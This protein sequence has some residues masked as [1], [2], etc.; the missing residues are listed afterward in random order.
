MSEEVSS[1]NSATSNTRFI[2]GEHQWDLPDKHPVKLDSEY[3]YVCGARAFVS[4]RDEL[5]ALV[6][7]GQP[8]KFVWTPDTP[9]P[10]YPEMVAF[11]LDALRANQRRSG[12]NTMFW[13][14]G[15]M[16]VAFL[17]A[18][19]A[20]DWH[21]VYRSFF[22][23]LGALFVAEGIWT[24]WSS[25]R[26]TQSDAISD[27]SAERFAEWLKKKK[28]SGYTVMLLACFVVV[29]IIQ[30]VAENSAA[31]TGLVKP[32][33]W[34]GEIW[35][36]LTATLMHANFTHFWMNF[37]GIIF[38]G[39]LIEHTMQ[40]ALVPLV[41]LLTAPVGSIFSVILYPNSTS[42]GASGGIM[43]L[44]GLVT[45]AAYSDRKRYPSKYF[46]RMIEVIVFTGVLG[47]F[48]FAFIDNAGH[49]GGLVGGLLLGWFVFKNERWIKEREKWL[50][51]AGV[52]ALFVLGF[53]AAFIV[54]RLTH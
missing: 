27:R 13:G 33:V 34:D 41:F 25:R 48:G 47:L 9:E 5:I 38:L 28:L 37:A 49:L 46:R 29:I 52:A 54:Y 40:R 22:F 39:R 44:I 17:I 30:P 35:R 20:Q 31:I 4:T 12:R 51:Y 2:P 24:Y 7:R 21:V 42:V 36:L 45:I 50:N 14:A 10:V 11:L 53:T 1:P 6:K 3:G 18:L 19:G 23:V 15:F 8:L 43:G 16:G 32:A 26:Y